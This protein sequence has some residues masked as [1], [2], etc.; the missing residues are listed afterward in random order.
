[1]IEG[2]LALAALAQRFEFTFV[3]GQQVVPDPTFTLRPKYGVQLTVR[4]RP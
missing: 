4:K 2:P 3:E 1:M